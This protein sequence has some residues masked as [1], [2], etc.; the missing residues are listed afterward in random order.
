MKKSLIYMAAAMTA[1]SIPMTSCQNEDEP[2]MGRGREVHLTVTAAR[3][4]MTRTSME[5]DDEANLV[6]K[7]SAGDQLGVFANTKNAGVLTIRQGE[8]GKVTS[9]FE[10]MVTIPEGTEEINLIYLGS[11]YEGNLAEVGN[12]VNIDVSAQDGTFESL[13]EKDVLGANALIEIFDG[14]AN[15]TAEMGRFLASGYFN[16]ALPD[17]IELAEGDVVTISSDENT[18]YNQFDYKLAPIGTALKEDFKGPINI[19]KAERGNDIY[20]TMF[21][22]TT[23][24]TF[25]VSKGGYIYTAHLGSHVWK[26][27]TY[28]RNADG[29]AIKVTDWTKTEKPIDPSD[30]NNWGGPTAKPQYTDSGDINRKYTDGGYICNDYSIYITGGWCTPVTFHS[31]GVVD[32]YLYS[33]TEVRPSYYQWGRWLGFPDVIG[34]QTLLTAYGQPSDD[35]YYWDTLL[36]VPFETAIKDATLGWTYVNTQY[37]SI[38]AG[39]FYRI[40]PTTWTGG[41][42]KTM[43]IK[44]SHLFAVVGATSGKRLD[45]L[46]TNENCNWEDRT[47]NPC[48]AGWR[49]PTIEELKVFMPSQA[50]NKVYA[51]V[52]TVNGSKVA[53]KWEK[54]TVKDG[55]N[56]IAAVKITS[57]P[58]TANSVTATDAIFSSDNASS[59]TIGAYGYLNNLGAQKDYGTR[60]ALW[61]CESGSD[62]NMTGYAGQSL[63]IVFDGDKMTFSV[64]NNHR[65]FG[66]N[67]MPIRDTKAKSTD[68]TPWFP[69]KWSV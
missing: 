63:I 13:T 47:G 60:A 33:T 28:V 66:L 54:T 61:S 8:E 49:I 56:T 7:W 37:N 26:P 45:Y 51:E 4:A 15:A 64:M 59:V 38:G 52:K 48:P 43:S 2:G 57:V 22:C 55:D 69:A 68:L 53:M 40:Q 12:R 67:V 25:T 27:A 9:V 31:S 32:G 1:F 17:G 62:S 18:I 11:G 19:T 16:L 3:D 50:V 34:K 36:S 44:A 30:F 42:D 6:C 41:W 35:D 58:T 23:S 29:S 21:N 14:T 46:K 65:V 20:L 39:Q 24:L 10:G 5:V